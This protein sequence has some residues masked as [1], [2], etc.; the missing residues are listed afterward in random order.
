[1]RISKPEEQRYAK[2]IQRRFPIFIQPLGF[3]K[4]AGTECARSFGQYTCK[5][6]L[7]KF[8][9]QAAMR[10][11]FSIATDSDSISKPQVEFSDRWTYCD[12]PGPK[13]YNFR[14]DSGENAVDT[15]LDEI[16]HFVQHVVIPW[17]DTRSESSK[18]L[19]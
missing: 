7:Q 5:V 15:C 19:G 11:I 13:K 4:S 18:T 9:H 10:V 8:R 1:M 14:I 2:A 12:S 6:G 16:Y 3:M 17:A